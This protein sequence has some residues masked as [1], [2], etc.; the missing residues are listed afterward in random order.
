MPVAGPKIGAAVRRMIER[1]GIKY[2]P[3]A[4][5]NAVD[6][7]KNE[8]VLD[9]G[10]RHKFD[11]LAVVP[12]HKA[13]EVVKEAGLLG[14]SA[15]APVNSATLETKHPCV[16]AIGDVTGIKLSNGKAL[17]K[18]GVFAHFEA[19]VVVSRIADEIKGQKPLKEFKGGGLC[20]LETGSGKAGLAFGNFYVKPD[21]KVTMMP[22]MKLWHWIKI[23][24]EKWWWKWF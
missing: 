3:K 12:P 18:A 22:P 23:L 1:Q 20:Y 19:E 2:F 16:F 13:P 24:F 9:N 11:L 17:P 4:K 6:N 21:P 7:Q 10:E 15:W 8:I 5:L 14:E